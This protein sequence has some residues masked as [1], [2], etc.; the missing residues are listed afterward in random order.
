MA[1]W[2]CTQC[3]RQVPDKLE[4]CRCGW[5]RGVDI[6]EARGFPWTALAVIALAAATGWAGYSL[7]KPKSAPSPAASAPS[8]GPVREVTVVE[9]PVP[10]R[11]PGA[12][13]VREVPINVAPPQ[14]PPP[15]PPQYVPDTL[16]PGAASSGIVEAALNA[17]PPALSSTEEMQQRAA[18]F[19]P[20][21]ARVAQ[22]SDHLD[23]N[24]R[25]YIDA[26]YR[27]FTVSSVSGQTTGSGQSYG[28]GG[29]FG[30]SWFAVWEGSSQLA[31]QESW[32]GQSVVSNESTVEC[33]M[34]WSDIEASAAQIRRD[35]DAID[36]DA[37]RAMVAPGFIRDLK[38][39]FRLS[40]E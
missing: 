23:N 11:E 34:L 15:Q 28:Y 12:A 40:F 14:E 36:D 33:R 8:T 1:V 32:T 7:A 37:R 26:C 25:R 22:V 10:Q 38:R 27:K 5:S 39:E 19:R 21:L 20:R 6:P 9:V 18:V 4:R 31:W 29:A 16:P 24:F 2:I 30:R 17:Q 13:S 35:I 3:K